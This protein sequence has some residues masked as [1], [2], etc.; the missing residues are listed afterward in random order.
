MQSFLSFSFISYCLVWHSRSRSVGRS[1]VEKGKKRRT[2]GR[3]PNTASSK[4]KRNQSDANVRYIYQKLLLVANTLLC[5][6]VC[7][8]LINNN[9]NAFN[10]TN[11]NN[12]GKKFGSMYTQSQIKEFRSRNI[13]TPNSHTITRVC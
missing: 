3:L 8:Y 13:S 7:C 6:T 12:R 9:T 5:L 10:Q 4:K 2:V 11:N 1:N